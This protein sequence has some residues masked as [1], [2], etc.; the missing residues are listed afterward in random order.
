MHIRLRSPAAGDGCA[1]NHCQ[2]RLLLVAR[3]AQIADTG[4]GLQRAKSR[5][6]QKKPL[7]D[8]LVGG[9][10]QPL[11]HVECE[12]VC[13]L[14]PT[15]INGTR[16]IIVRL[17]EGSRVRCRRWHRECDGT[18]NDDQPRRRLPHE[19]QQEC[20]GHECKAACTV[21]PRGPN[22]GVE[23]GERDAHD[24]G[25]D[26]VER[27]LRPRAPTQFIRKRK[28]ESIGCPR[29]NKRWTITQIC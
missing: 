25:V 20:R 18:E 12:R 26:A 13:V 28:G 23:R 3:L 22:R 15:T 2:P 21:D 7:F 29:R 19:Q 1:A 11:R 17:D 5:P 16:M 10:H 8:D 4:A 6:M 27:R 24:G 14:T 9:D